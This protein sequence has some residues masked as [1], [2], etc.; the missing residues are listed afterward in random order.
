MEYVVT[1]KPKHSDERGFLAEF[2]TRSE[3]APKAPFGHIYFVTFAK[4]GVIRGNHYHKKK[5]EY[6]G[7]A[8]GKVKLVI[9]DIKTGEKKTFIL[10]D[11]N[12]EFVRIKIA[13]KIAHTVQSLSDQAVLIDYFSQPYDPESPDDYRFM[14][15]KPLK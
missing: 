1:R 11:N 3:L 4:R 13:P 12:H 14:L 5:N 10:S 7:I 9:K 8:Y 2:L 6:F 15:I